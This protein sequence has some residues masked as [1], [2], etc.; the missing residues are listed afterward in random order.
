MKTTK[1]VVLRH[2]FPKIYVCLRHYVYCEGDAAVAYSTDGDGVLPGTI[3][4]MSHADADTMIAW[5]LEQGFD[6]V[7]SHPE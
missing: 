5:A 1:I 4:H 3:M 6:L 2:V 7:M